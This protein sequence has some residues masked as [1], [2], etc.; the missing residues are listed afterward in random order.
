MS[1]ADTQLEVLSQHYSET[2]ELLKNDAA[3][4]DRLFLYI[5][6]VIFLLLLSL[7]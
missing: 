6:I 3:K 7:K 2:F 4:R 5:L 1:N